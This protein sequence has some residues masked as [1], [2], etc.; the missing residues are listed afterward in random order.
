L[1]AWIG[2]EP[3][4]FLFGCV[5]MGAMLAAAECHKDARKQKGRE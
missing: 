3:W 5:S 1:D 4:A 2:Q